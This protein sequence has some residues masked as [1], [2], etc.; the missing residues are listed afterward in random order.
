[1][2]RLITQVITKYSISL[3]RH[4]HAIRLFNSLHSTPS[5]I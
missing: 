4:I 5:F 3:V 2:L 1:M